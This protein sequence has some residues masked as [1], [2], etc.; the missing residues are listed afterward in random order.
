[1]GAPRPPRSGRTRPPPSSPPSH[2][3]HAP[4]PADAILGVSL[5]ADIAPNE[6]GKFNRAFVSLFR[7]AAGDTWVDS[8]PALGPDGDLEWKPALYVCTFI[9]L[10]V[11]IVLQVSVAVLLDNFVTVSMRMQNEE[12]KRASRE[13]KKASR[14]QNPLEPLIRKLA[15]EYTDDASLSARLSA[16]FQARWA[17]PR[18]RSRNLHR[19]PAHTRKDVRAARLGFAMSPPFSGVRV[20]PVRVRVVPS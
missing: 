2:S 17:C 19:T 1:M 5:F 20:V 18:R 7:L 15:D 16:L 13:R 4:R 6:F 9:V 10:S 3:P 11:W 8:L 12:K 14:F